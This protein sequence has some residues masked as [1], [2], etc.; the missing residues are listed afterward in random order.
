M[1]R[2]AESSSHSALVS[3]NNYRQ[4][5]LQVALFFCLRFNFFCPFIASHWHL[6]SWN[7]REEDTGRK[8]KRK[9]I[10]KKGNIPVGS[11]FVQLFKLTV[12]TKVTK[13]SPKGG[14]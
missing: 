9:K 10:L 8:P 1:W 14:D 7:E 3:C 12:G 6:K 13:F 5:L 2:R 11:W 4:E